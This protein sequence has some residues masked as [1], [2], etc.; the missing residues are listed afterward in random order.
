L[1]SNWLDGKPILENISSV[2]WIDGRPFVTFHHLTLR[3]GFVV[4]GNTL[5]E[6][7]NITAEKDVS[8]ETITISGNGSVTVVGISDTSANITISG[9]GSVSVTGVSDTG[10]DVTVSGNGSI[11]ITY[12]FMSFQGS[13]IINESSNID[14]LIEENSYISEEIDP[15]SIITEAELELTSLVTIVMEGDSEII[16]G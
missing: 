5:T 10:V 6:P 11:A 4:L 13:E 3:T 9:N 12:N 7:I 15:N 8:S 1:I 14:I 16:D 2:D